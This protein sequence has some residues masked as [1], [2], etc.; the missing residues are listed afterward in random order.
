MVFAGRGMSRNNA[1]KNMWTDDTDGGNL[2]PSPFLINYVCTQPPI[3]MLL[4]TMNVYKTFLSLWCYT[5]TGGV[6][7]NA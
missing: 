5:L 3:S 4:R 2:F 6:G 1:G 7:Q